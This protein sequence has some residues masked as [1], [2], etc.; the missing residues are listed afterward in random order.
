[1]R[2]G[3]HP[4][5]WTKVDSG[6]RSAKQITCILSEAE[7][8]GPLIP[9]ADEFWGL[10]YLRMEASLLRGTICKHYTDDNEDAM[11]LLRTGGTLEP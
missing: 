7:T 5:A 2:K 4:G 8:S 3:V 10:G 1:M 11:R 6:R 9:R